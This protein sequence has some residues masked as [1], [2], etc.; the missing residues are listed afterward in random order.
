MIV[1]AEIPKQPNPNPNP[2]PNPDRHVALAPTPFLTPFLS[3][4]LNLKKLSLQ[5]KDSLNNERTAM[6]KFNFH[7]HSK[8]DDGTEAL[9]EYVK[10]AIDKGLSAMGF[11]GHS[12]LPFDN[13]WSIGSGDYPE[14]V[15]EMKRLREKYKDH[16]DIHIGLELDYIP[17]YSDNF[18]AFFEGAGLD[19]CIGSVHLVMKPGSSD[20]NDIWFIDGPREGYLKG[21]QRIYNG[22][23]RR[24]VEAYYDQQREMVATQRP[25]IIGHLDK[26]NMHNQGELF[27]TSSKWYRSAID[28]LLETI[29]GH[30]TI[31]ELNTRGVYTGKTN[32]YFPGRELLEKCLERDI[33]VMVNTDAHHP[34][35]L[36]NHFDDAVALLKEVGFRKMH[37]PFF[38]VAIE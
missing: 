37:T 15:A 25:D 14:Y 23:V 20:A 3:P 26:V 27:D 34:S 11:S 12:P 38:D 2:N 21:I 33:K 1:N 24:A 7:T 16:I 4:F 31:V 19:Y 18:R 13:E 17:G 29:A 5:S 32:E 8:Y 35:Q 22:D 9:E 30:G 10:A 36:D 6:T 28:R